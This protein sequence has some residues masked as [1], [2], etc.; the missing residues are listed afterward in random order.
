M[1][2]RVQRLT[3]KLT[4][5]AEVEVA[6]RS[7]A[8]LIPGLALAGAFAAGL[9]SAW[10]IDVA[11]D[12]L[13]MML[14]GVTYSVA[15][16]FSALAR[17]RWYLPLV[18]AYLPFSK[19]FPLPVAGLSGANLINLVLAAGPLAWFVTRAQGKPRTPL[20]LVE[21]VLALFVV[22]TSAS[23]VPA[24]FAGHDLG[25]IA[26][27]YRAWVGPILFFFL[28]R[29]LVRDRQDVNAIL[30]VLAWTAVLVTLC[31]WWEGFERS[32]RGSIES[33]RVPGVLLQANSMGAFLV[34][35]G[36]PLLALALTARGWKR[37]IGYFLGFVAAARAV[38][39]TFSRGAY[40]AF[41]AGSSVVLFCGNPA[42]L[43]VAGGASLTAV[44]L[45]PSL[46]PL[47]VQQRFSET[48]DP[49]SDIGS[50][51]LDK[52]S[53]LRLVL[54]KGGLQMVAEHPLQGV[55]L[56][57]FAETVRDHTPDPLAPDDPVDAHNAYLLLAA[58]AGVPS[59][60]L[61]LALFSAW[62]FTALKLYL[63]RRDPVD[64]RLGLVFLGSLVGVMVSCT[65]GSRFSEEALIGY[66]WILAA[67]VVV[68]GRWPGR[69]RPPAAA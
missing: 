54:W 17:P 37:G 27:N 48:S 28:A 20:G 38:L 11:A 2:S 34:Y 10:T 51:A 29:G 49:D 18:V 64:R 3:G 63:R 43:A 69:A 36:V 60:I 23:V 26:Q 42:L 5:Q 56:A 61:L 24:Y 7:R 41:V 16:L 40:L 19:A 57:R 52:S 31:T 12:G 8:E 58:E 1:A 50:P 25:E 21:L 9:A 22:A 47:S 46:V 14:F 35:Y 32:D 53:A 65:V 30:Q 66:F 44:A 39:Y 67:L 55:G 62:G 15:L 6:L 68:V 33:S 4:T 45:F 13:V 59:L